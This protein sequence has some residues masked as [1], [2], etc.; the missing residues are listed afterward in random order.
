MKRCTEKRWR[1]FKGMV[2]G[3]L[4][5]ERPAIRTLDDVLMNRER[6]VWRCKKNLQIFLQAVDGVSITGNYISD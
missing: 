1:G 4:A 3:G 6:P 5:P 2:Q